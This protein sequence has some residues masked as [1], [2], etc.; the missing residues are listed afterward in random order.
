MS[1]PTQTS[2]GARIVGAGSHAS[3]G[4]GPYVMAASTLEGD[5]VYSSDNEE[6]GKI[7]E[8]MLD[9]Q[10]GRI[11]YAVM[12]SGGFLGIGDKLLALPW[13]AL[14]LDAQ[15]KCFVL[16][17][18]A[19]RVKDAPGFDKDHWPAMADVGWATTLHDYYGVRTQWQDD[20][21]EPPEAGGIKL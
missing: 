16:N 12:S 6:I 14:A 17:V 2:S 9:V 21:A 10:Q 19:A 15:R 7:K 11:V 5:H 18:T 3:D 20:P 8:I 1:I 13:P 4:P